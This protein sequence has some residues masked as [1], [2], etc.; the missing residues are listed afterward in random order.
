MREYGLYLGL[1]R[2]NPLPISLPRMATIIFYQMTLNIVQREQALCLQL[3]HR[4]VQ[5]AVRSRVLIRRTVPSNLTTC[6]LNKLKI[7]FFSIGRLFRMVQESMR[8]CSP[9]FS[10]KWATKVCNQAS[11][12]ILHLTFK[13]LGVSHL[14]TVLEMGRVDKSYRR[15][16]GSS[17]RATT[18][19]GEKKEG[20]TICCSL[21]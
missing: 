3:V 19:F 21:Q 13:Q 7:R 10:Y 18:S 1:Y 8:A 17:L 9:T 11:K 2:S 12:T 6:M 14:A 15:Q 20:R 5:G 16:G 4:T